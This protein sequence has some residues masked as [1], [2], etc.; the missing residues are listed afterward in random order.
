MLYGNLLDWPQ[1]LEQN[2]QSEE[3]QEYKSDQLQSTKNQ[4]FRLK[5]KIILSSS[6]PLVKF[7]YF[8][9]SIS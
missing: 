3:T 7:L 2:L 9:Q 5:V 6:R 1:E 8:P 4:K